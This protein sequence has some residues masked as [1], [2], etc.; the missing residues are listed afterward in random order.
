MY[1]AD[2]KEKKS[3][4]IEQIEEGRQIKIKLSTRGLIEGTVLRII[5]NDGTGPIIIGVMSSRIS[6]GRGLC[7][8]IK[9]K[10]I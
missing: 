10:E 1:L 5:K 9:V 7:N 2:G 4:R 3:Y 6:L 8:K